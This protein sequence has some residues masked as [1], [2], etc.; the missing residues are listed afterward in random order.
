MPKMPQI[1][2]VN[3]ED[4]D[5]VGVY[6]DGKLVQQDHSLDCDDILDI[7]KIE[8]KSYWVNMEDGSRLPGDLAEVNLN[9]PSP[10]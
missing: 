3:S 9:R 7:L 2:F 8:Y 5:W 4:G 6:L 1:T 10:K